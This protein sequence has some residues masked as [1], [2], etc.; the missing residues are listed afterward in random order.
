MK[1]I[2]TWSV[3]QVI[4]VNFWI[5]LA[6]SFYW[7][8]KYCGWGGGYPKHWYC[9][10]FVEESFF[11]SA[12]KYKAFK[13]QML[14]LLELA[15]YNKKISGDK[16][17]SNFLRFY[18]QCLENSWPISATFKENYIYKRTDELWKA[19]WK[20][21]YYSKWSFWMLFNVFFNDGSPAL[22]SMLHWAH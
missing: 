22:Q 6:S 3:D 11:S 8:Q 5:W 1:N 14:I 9:I 4:S 15:T 12:F 7:L 18:M 13:I 16:K 21:M 10:L 17:P 2:S 19:D 20:G